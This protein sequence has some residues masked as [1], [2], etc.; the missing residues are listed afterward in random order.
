VLD[1]GIID[2]TSTCTYPNEG[3]LDPVTLKVR[4]EV[5]GAL[6]AALPRHVVSEAQVLR[7]PAASD[8]TAACAPNGAAGA[9]CGSGILSLG[10]HK[11]FK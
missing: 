6:V 1:A 2:L 8:M 4:L 7:S 10:Q 5:D 3:L 11:V 9:V